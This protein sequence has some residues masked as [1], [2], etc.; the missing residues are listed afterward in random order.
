MIHYNYIDDGNGTIWLDRIDCSGS[1]HK[2]INC[3]YSIDTSHCSHRHD[4]GVKCYLSCPA[5]EDEGRLRFITGSIENIGRLEINYRGEWGTIC[6][7]YFGHVEAEVACRQLGYCSGQMIPYNYIDDGNGT[8]WL[9][10][11]DCSG[12]EHKLINCSYSIETSH[13]SHRHDAGVKCYLSCP[14]EEDE[15]DGNG[16]IWLDRIDCSGS[17]HKLINCSYSIDTSHCSHR[18]DAGVKC[19]LSCPAEEDEDDGNGTIWLDRID[20]SGSEHKLINCS[21]SIDTSHCSHRHD[22][23]VKCY[24][25]CPAEEDEGRLRFITGSIENIGRLEINYRGKWGTICDTYFGH[26]EAEVACRQLGYCSGQM[27]HYNYIDDG[28]G[29]IWL[30]RIDC[31]GS[32]HKLINCS[33]SIDTSHCSHRHDAGVK[34]YLSCPAEEDEGRLRFITGSIENIG[35]LEINYRG[36]WGTICDTYFGHVE[37]E[38]ACRQLGYCSGQMIHYNYID[39]GNGTIWLDR[40]DCSGSEHKLINCTYSID[41]SHCSH[42]H[43]AGVKCY[44]SCPAEE[45][46][47]DGNGTIWLDRIDCS[48]SEHKLINCTY[49]IDTSHCSHR[50]DAGVK[51]YLSCPAEEDEGRLRFITGSIENIGRLEINYR[52]E[53]GTI[54]ST[55]F[56]HV[57]AEVACRQLGYCSGQM[58]HYNYI[59]D[60]NGTIWLDR[61]DCSGSEHKLINCSYSIDTSHCSHRHDAG[62]KCYLSCP[63]EEDEGR[64]RFITGSI[65]NIGRLEIN[66]RG[67]WGQYVILTLMMAMEPFARENRLPGSEHKLINCSYS[68]DTSHCSHKRHDAGVKCYLSCPAEEDE[69]RL[70]FITGSIENIGRLE[71]NYR[72]EWGTICDTY[73]VMEAEVAC[74]QPDIAYNI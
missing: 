71:I 33:Y 73:L 6:S 45:D 56:G 69:G 49:S 29:T 42:R 1:E 47:D 27:I 54:C 9:D 16:T 53:W 31:S 20:C 61:I 5:E 62:V 58:I 23:G 50:H 72:G 18:H 39:D 44:L 22:A 60:G 57:E 8:I 26:V 25:S 2:L 11:I 66:Y 21:Y 24:L 19:Y 28:N 34:C 14:A 51:C 37:A 63:A 67:E 55:Y 36:E 15:D 17:E 59:D 10:R 68:I 43:D 41:T 38:V 65:E 3:S 35:R 46:E 40:I 48:G 12:S 52:G 4:A 74:R 7:T 30:D 13:C 70:R 32:E 64:L